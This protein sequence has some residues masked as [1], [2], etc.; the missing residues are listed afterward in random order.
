MIRQLRARK[1]AAAFW[2]ALAVAVPAIL[3]PA[4]AM[5]SCD[6][7]QECCSGRH[8]VAPR[9]VQLTV[10]AVNRRF[11]E[12]SFIARS[13]RASRILPLI[14]AESGG[15]PTCVTD[16]DSHSAKRPYGWGSPG[17][18]T[19][20]WET[21]EVTR[22]LNRPKPLKYNLTSN[23]GL[24]QQ[25]ADVLTSDSSGGTRRIF[26]EYRDLIK[27]DP[28]AALEKCA[29]RDFYSVRV[30]P[31]DFFGSAATC[32]LESTGKCFGKVV[33]L[34]P[35]LNVELGL[36]KLKTRPGY[37]QNYRKKPLCQDYLKKLFKKVEADL[38]ENSS[39]KGAA[40]QHS[41]QKP[42]GAPG[43]ASQGD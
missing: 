14:I 38:S 37:F 5:A 13:M 7:K 30:G 31:E 1:A 40:P 3:T 11:Q 16:T 2:A 17:A 15:D 4:R 28:A 21:T 43:G 34:C 25:S 10:T 20:K 29:S 36:Q 39:S 42:K 24:M 32:K 12:E 27:K 6:P 22:G 33:M 26:N 23:F 8:T 9:L 18:N 19:Y 41:I 35:A